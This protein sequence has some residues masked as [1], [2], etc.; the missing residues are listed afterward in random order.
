M[1]INSMWVQR[2]LVSLLLVCRQYCKVSKTLQ[3][4]ALKLAMDAHLQI[5]DHLARSIGCCVNASKAQA[6]VHCDPVP[7]LLPDKIASPY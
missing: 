5:K 6:T 2:G 3:C 4:K 7:P 1:V